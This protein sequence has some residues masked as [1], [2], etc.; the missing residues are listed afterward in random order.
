MVHIPILVPSVAWRRQC[1]NWP[2][3]AHKCSTEPSNYMG[4]EWSRKNSS[5][6]NVVVFTRGTVCC[7]GKNNSW[8][9]CHLSSFYNCLWLAFYT[10]IFLQIPT[11]EMVSCRLFY[12]L[13]L[14]SNA[15]TRLYPDH[16][17]HSNRFEVV[18][19][20]EAFFLIKEFYFNIFGKFKFHNKITYCF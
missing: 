12:H 1:F 11:Y 14:Y 2:D 3:L 7:D 10:S 6:E 16:I 15:P 8:V 9:F 4:W 17:K 19:L 13:F 20:A 18:I 5:S